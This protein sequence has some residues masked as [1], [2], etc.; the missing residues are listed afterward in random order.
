MPSSI[1][2]QICQVTLNKNIE[3]AHLFQ[4]L[5]LNKFL[6]ATTSAKNYRREREED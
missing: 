3:I 6:E 2:C 1:L 4:P 5:L